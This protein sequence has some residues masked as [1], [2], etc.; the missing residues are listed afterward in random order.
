MMARLR[1]SVLAGLALL[2]L[3]A[4]SAGPEVS[5]SS[6]DPFEN[7]NR[8][9]H[10]FNKALDQNA[11]RPIANAYGEAV[12]SPVRTGVA[13]ATSNLGEPL[14]FVNHS[15]QGDFD[16][17]AST[18]F[19]FALNTI[20][21]FGGVLDIATEAGI[22]ERETDFGETLAVWGVPSGA[23]LEI[24]VLGPST[25]RDFAGFIVDIGI[26]P[27]TFTGVVPGDVQPYLAGAQVVDIINLRYEFGPIIDAL[28]Y[29]SADS[30]AAARIAYLQN[31]ARALSG[32]AVTEELLE[33][34]YAF[35]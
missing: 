31:R 32:G 18:F 26:N 23:Y 14:A 29:Q 13:N 21:G 9:I 25:Q 17:A 35:E 10:E 22:V 30:Y 28:Y 19:R 1:M 20:F 7:T 12:P 8:K 34:P 15:L 33:D 24:P 4:C 11:L 16:D 27:L 3:G 2:A 5:A 6:E